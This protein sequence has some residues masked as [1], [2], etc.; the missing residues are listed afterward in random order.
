VIDLEMVALQIRISRQMPA[1]KIVAEL[2]NTRSVCAG[3]FRIG[4]LA[5]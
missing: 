1:E 2:E 3:I 4:R 5:Y